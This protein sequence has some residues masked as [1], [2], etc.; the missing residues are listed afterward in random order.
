VALLRAALTVCVACGPTTGRSGANGADEAAVPGAPT[1]ARP[2]FLRRVPADTPF[3]F[4]SLA[5]IPA[6]YM[7]TEYLSRVTA[8]QPV[9]ERLAKLRKKRPDAFARLGVP[10]RLRAALLAELGARRPA[11]A[12][13]AI[14]LDRSPRWILYG[15]GA[16]P[17]IRVELRDPA[18]AALA[19]ERIL[20]WLQPTE[21]RTAGKTAYHQL[22]DGT[23]RWVFAI[24]RRDLVV[25]ILPKAAPE[26]ALA[27]ALG[28]RDPATSLADERRLERIAGEV[29]AAGFS[30][31]YVETRALVSQLSLEMSVACRDEL[32]EL[33]RLAPTISFGVR[34]ASG[35]R[36]EMVSFIETRGDLARSL[37]AM[38]GQMPGPADLDSV[39]AASFTIGL[40]VDLSQAAT[41]LDEAFGK[42]RS[43]PYNCSALDWL[44]R[45]AREQGFALGWLSSSPFGKVR[46][47]TALVFA[48]D[49]P[50]G[51]AAAPRAPAGAIVLLGAEQRVA[52]LQAIAG[53]FPLGLP[54]SMAPG[55]PPVAITAAAGLPMAPIHLAVGDSA[56]GF[57]AGGHEA[58]LSQLLAAAPASEPPLVRIGIDL[59]E[60]TSLFGL[61]GQPPDPVLAE[62]DQVLAGEIAEIDGRALFRY[63]E[64][65]FDFSPSSRGVEMKMEGRYA[66]PR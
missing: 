46:G 8:Y 65:W 20:A 3:V 22:D 41:I 43:K 18:V 6:G 16:A 44:N 40:A 66:R 45:L 2:D 12:L 10:L 9:A 56:L 25:A 7:E 42:I 60:V 54:T 5:P 39:V 30:V 14:G 50:A 21:K 4:A 15:V 55:D 24:D 27:L 1:L 37:M 59:R 28:A 38:R 61:A 11:D 17:V 47:L 63:H 29:G 64:L 19:L 62:I 52:L 35:R 13:E 58:D 32:A 26:S 57:A 48:G 53:L 33:A 31:G 23:R 49:A 36:V 34:R 51:A